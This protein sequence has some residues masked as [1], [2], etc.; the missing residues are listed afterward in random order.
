ML[1]KLFEIR[2][3]P[4][5]AS[6]PQASVA[7]ILFLKVDLA[8]KDGFPLAL[9]FRHFDVLKVP[10]WV[11]L[12][13]NPGGSEYSPGACGCAPNSHWHFDARLSLILAGLKAD[14]FEQAFARLGYFCNMSKPIS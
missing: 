14:L 1:D 7:Q 8:R 6:I 10:V 13:L 9:P 12:A 11:L 3:G 4:E 5:V 2:P